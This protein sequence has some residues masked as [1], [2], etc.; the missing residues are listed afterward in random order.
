MLRARSEP[1]RSRG[2]SVGARAPASSRRWRAEET[3][4]REHDR[5]AVPQVSARASSAALAPFAL[6]ALS[7]SGCGGGAPLLHPAHTLPDGDVA[8]AAGTSG[9]LALGGLRDADEALDAAAS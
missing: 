5:F 1:R 3:R 7:L 4:R 2:R 6:L 8:F 9:R